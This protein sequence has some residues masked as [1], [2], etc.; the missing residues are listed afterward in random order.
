MTESLIWSVNGDGPTDPEIVTGIR[1]GPAVRLCPD[2]PGPLAS[3]RPVGRNRPGRWAASE[4]RTGDGRCPPDPDPIRN[5]ADRTDRTAG[6]PDP[7]IVTAGPP[8]GGKPE[9]AVGPGRQQ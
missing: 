5:G 8:E 7:E 1:V 4:S 9:T 6:P 3:G 2:G